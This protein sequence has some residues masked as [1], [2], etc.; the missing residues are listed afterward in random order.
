MKHKAFLVK[1]FVYKYTSLLHIVHA[2]NF[3]DACKKI[4]EK[5]PKAH[6]FVNWTI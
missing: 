3:D 6:G 4:L 5:Y 1:F 2:N